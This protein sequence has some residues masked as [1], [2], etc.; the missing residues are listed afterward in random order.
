MKK[1]TGGIALLALL[2]LFTASA[3]AQKDRMGNFEIQRLMSAF[4]QAET[5][6]SN[7]QKIA[8]EPVPAAIASVP[9]KAEAWKNQSAQIEAV[10]LDLMGY[11]KRLNAALSDSVVTSGELR[12][13]RSPCT[14]IIGTKLDNTG[15]IP[16][17]ARRREAVLTAFNAL[18]TNEVLKE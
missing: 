18:C 6:S 13:L 9:E 8:A 7:V 10:I 17:I 2:L 15:G 5:L 16:L 4:N 12:D 11:V 14:Q 1:I 3:H